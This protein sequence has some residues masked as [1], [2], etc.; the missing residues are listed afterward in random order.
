MQ[1]D[2][3]EA[4]RR[5]ESTDTTNTKQQF[6]IAKTKFDEVAL[7]LEFGVRLWVFRG[8]SE[9]SLGKLHVTIDECDRLLLCWKAFVYI[10]VCAF[11]LEHSG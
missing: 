8:L 9:P 7:G 1:V 10:P 6:T 4:A 11:L 5:L 3:L 2:G